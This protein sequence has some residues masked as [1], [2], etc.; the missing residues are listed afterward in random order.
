MLPEVTVRLINEG[1]GQRLESRTGSGGNYLI[2]G[3]FAGSTLVG[4]R[5]NR[6]QNI[7]KLRTSAEVAQSATL[8]LHLEI[9]SLSERV[10]ITASAPV[11]NRE[12]ATVGQ[13]IE[14][15]QILDMPLNGRNFLQLGLLVPGASENPGA[16]SQFSITACEAI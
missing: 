2:S 15:K 4:G 3:A 10:E 5:A 12:T 6:I 8:D 13:A 9:G 14:N 16:Q 11:L 7:S 1:T